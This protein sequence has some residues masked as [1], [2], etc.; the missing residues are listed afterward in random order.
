MKLYLTRHAQSLENIG[1]KLIKDTS[2]TD[3]G[4]EQAKRL[5]IYFKKLDINLIF[6]SKLKR[7]KETLDYIKPYLR[8]IKIVYTEKIN[9]HDL[10]HYFDQGLDFFKFEKDAKKHSKGIYEFK[11]KN[12]ESY[13]ELFERAG[14]FY[15]VLR[16]QKSKNVLVVGHG[17]FTKFLIL[18]ILGLDISEERYFKLNNASV[19]SF[20]IDKKKVMEFHVND[21]NHILREGIRKNGV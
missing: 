14:K 13:S 19:S 16:K 20:Y 9:E 21:S 6:C 3:V 17:Q 1:I 12:G 2:L 4:K 15:N 5:G 11:P 8:G 18:K 7:A 10:G